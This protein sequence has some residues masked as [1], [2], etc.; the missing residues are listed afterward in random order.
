MRGSGVVNSGGPLV[1]LAQLAEAIATEVRP[2]TEVERPD[3]DGSPADHYHSDGR[4]WA[5]TCER[6]GFVPASLE[7][8]I[9]RT[10]AGLLPGAG[11]D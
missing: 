1:E 5:A 8:Q 6:L 7:E 10:A 11:D 4:A 2:G 9:K 3:P